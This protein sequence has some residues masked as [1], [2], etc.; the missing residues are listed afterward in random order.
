MSAPQNR[1]LKATSQ[2]IKIVATLLRLFIP[3]ATILLS[4]LM[5]A[6]EKTGIIG[7]Y[8]PGS[9]V[10]MLAVGLTE[11]AIIAVLLLL[12]LSRVRSLVDSAISGDPFVSVNAQLLRQVGWLW[13]AINS[14]QTVC[15]T[16]KWLVLT[17]SGVHVGLDPS[18]VPW[19]GFFGALLIFV[20]A[21]VFQ[22]G[23]RMRADL[24][25][26]V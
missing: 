23:S 10:R 2:A 18:N 26:T 12:I 5:V 16:A 4:I 20:L 1:L 3:V 6:P 9:I 14:T 24:D 11:D 22:Q 8:T 21:G 17:G 25:G 19:L 15:N 7:Q 13:L